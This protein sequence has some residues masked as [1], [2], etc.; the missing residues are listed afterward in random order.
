VP[1]LP[2]FL[3]RFSLNVFGE[4]G[5][6]WAEGYTADLAAMRDVGAEI[7]VD[8]GLGARLPLRMRFGG[9]VALTDWLDTARGSGRFYLAFGRA[10]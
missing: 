3:D 1:K 4:V 5:S 9:A 2:F 8:V 7:A 6:G 10:F